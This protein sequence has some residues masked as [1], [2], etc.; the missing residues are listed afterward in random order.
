MRRKTTAAT[1]VQCKLQRKFS[2][3]ESLCYVPL[4]TKQPCNQREILYKIAIF[5]S[6]I[7]ASVNMKVYPAEIGAGLQVCKDTNFLT[8][9]L[10]KWEEIISSPY[11]K[12][13]CFAK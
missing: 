7:G 13:L 2:A 8:Q 6:K 10:Q 5:F 12:S 9:V 1:T 11:D 3:S 4:C